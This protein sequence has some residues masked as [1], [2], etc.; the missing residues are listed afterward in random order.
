MWLH[1]LEICKIFVMFVLIHNKTF[2]FSKNN[3]YIK[4]YILSYINIYIFYIRNFIY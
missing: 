4:K 2:I 1:F 3:I